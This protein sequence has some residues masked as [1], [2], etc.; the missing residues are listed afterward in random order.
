MGEKLMKCPKCGNTDINY[1]SVFFIAGGNV[2]KHMNTDK[3]YGDAT[4]LPKFLWYLKQGKLNVAGGTG[5][6]YDWT[7]NGVKEIECLKCHTKTEPTRF[8]I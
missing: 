6:F 1:F 4:T 5:K 3:P 2:L 7:L 8:G